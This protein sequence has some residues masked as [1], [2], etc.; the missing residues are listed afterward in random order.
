M[1]GTVILL[2]LLKEHEHFLGPNSALIY[3]LG[4]SNGVGSLTLMV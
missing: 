1:N 3:S 2:L 4:D